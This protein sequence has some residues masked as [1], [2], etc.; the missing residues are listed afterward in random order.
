MKNKKICATYI[1]NWLLAHKLNTQSF[2]S[3]Q[4][5]AL[6]FMCC[7]TINVFLFFAKTAPQIVFVKLSLNMLR[8]QEL[9]YSFVSAISKHLMKGPVTTWSKSVKSGLY[10]KILSQLMSLASRL[11]SEI[12]TGK[13]HF[14]AIYP[15]NQK[16]QLTG[17]YCTRFL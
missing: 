3:I 4:S 2:V 5:T 9:K 12:C 1:L 11:K 13:I 17:I 14:F 16:S 7:C 10:R 6:T 8:K 15:F